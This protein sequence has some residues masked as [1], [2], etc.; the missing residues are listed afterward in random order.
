M[1]ESGRKSTVLRVGEWIAALIGAANC[2]VVP[3][4]FIQPGGAFPFPAL[5]LIEIAL[6]GLGVLY[7]VFARLQ[8]DP[9]WDVVPW[10]AAGIMLAFVILGG[11][12]IGPYLIP[13]LIAYAGLGVLIEWETDGLSLVKNLGLLILAAVAQGTIMLLATLLA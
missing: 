5:Y 12:S 7:Y 9:R 10:L 3:F 13:A 2:L 8:L 6:V 11:F 4:L 1:D